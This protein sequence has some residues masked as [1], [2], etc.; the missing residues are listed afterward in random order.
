M[1]QQKRI[2]RMVFLLALCFLFLCF[3]TRT[4]YASE[5]RDDLSD[6]LQNEVD[7]GNNDRFNKGSPWLDNA[8][9]S[10]YSNSVDATEEDKNIEPK[11]PG[12][13][14]KYF[15]ELIRNTASSLISLLE[16]N[17]GAGL[18]RIIY[19]RV[20]SGQPNRVN[21]YSF[22]LKSGNPY[23]VTAAVC[24]SLVRSM[25]F[26]FLGISFVFLLA[27]SAWTGQTAASREQIKTSFYSTAVKFSIL[28]LMPYL[29]DVVLYVRD[30]VLY[31]IKE[32]TG[33]M[34]TGGA[35]LSLAKAF[36]INAER[37][38]RFIDALMYL[39]TVI[40]TL[41]FAVIYIAI[42]IDMLICF[43]FFP[44]LCV[45]HS[46]KRD[47]L[48]SWMMTVLSNIL[49]PVLDAILLLIPLLTSLMLSDVVNGIAII[50]MIMCMLII[51]SRNRIKTLLGVQ[52]NERGG[53]MSAMALMA[54]GRTVA[55]KAKNAFGKIGDIRSDM[56]KSRMHKDMAEADEEEQSSMLGGYSPS[57]EGQRGPNSDNLDAMQ[58]DQDR[59]QNESDR[60]EMQ[61][62]DEAL[63]ENADL[64]YGAG[65]LGYADD[66]QEQFMD[67]SDGDGMEESRAANFGAVPEETDLASEGPTDSE[68]GTSQPLTRNEA[69]RNLDKAMEQKQE[70]IDGLRTKKAA[71]QNEEKRIARQ[72][73]DHE[74]GTEEYRDLEK[75]RA[76]ASI[77]A[78]ETEQKIAG[79]MQ[80]MN[81]LRN[82]A[83]AIK[84][85]ETGPVPTKFDE[86]RAD[87]ICKRANISN[88]EQPE[89]KNALSNA[90]MQKLYKQRAM[91]NT[92]KGV[93]AAAGAVAG[94][95]LFGGASM[96]MQPSTAAMGMAAGA[97]SGAAVGGGTVDAGIAASRTIRSVAQPVGEIGRAYQGIQ[98]AAAAGVDFETA[99]EQSPMAPVPPLTPV[100]RQQKVMREIENVEVSAM[101]SGG[102][103]NTSGE[104]ANA[105]VNAT[106]AQVRIEVESD[107][108]EAMKKVV[109]ASGNWRSSYAL[110]ALEKANI[111]TERYLTS[112][113][114]TQG[115]SFT[116]KQEREKRI[117]LQTE[118]L[119]KEVLNKLSMQSDYEKGTDKYNVAKEMI[120][121]KIRA[122]VEK[123]NKNIF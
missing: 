85:S 108:A 67:E 103:V 87:M 73:L 104:T 114:E 7:E 99:Y 121:E 18:D 106:R 12:T 6:D 98:I 10:I 23:G 90:Q 29:F 47:L 49:T 48:G 63:E 111:E 78:S 86:A 16:D 39:G 55:G 100:Q 96:F 62:M 97:I 53:L 33:Q 123:K 21:I 41:F 89:F 74:R 120:E 117:E 34:I 11:K 84:G 38:G 82:Q 64:A 107:S 51:P 122:I 42:A 15:S 30:V 35:T 71:Y 50:Q 57:D 24:Y 19:G 68:D 25:A 65:E 115:I 69:L 88:F 59:E 44:I 4:V 37:S 112:L 14:E 116:P 20:G 105:A 77:H 75:K 17:L 58:S 95:T 61:P 93:T 45:I 31:G 46:K 113:R 70:T 76:D 13:V 83:K 80:G 118:F 5:L 3:G 66:A 109:T 101:T 92:A 56:Q 36:L 2:K 8:D 102:N 72:M 32:V 26:I 43:V 119:T 27:K 60:P 22:E 9:D 91:A 28:T 52:S 81:Q 110:Q 79:H 1:K 40:L 54:L 94:A